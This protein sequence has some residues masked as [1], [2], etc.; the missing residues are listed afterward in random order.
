MFISVFLFVFDEIVIQSQC[1]QRLIFIGADRGVVIPFD[2]E[3]N[4]A[5]I[6]RRIFDQPVDIHVL[7][8][9]KI[10]GGSAP[11]GLID[12]VGILIVRVLCAR[13]Y[14]KLRCKSMR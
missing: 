12:T 1:I 14:G 8:V 5:R 6:F 4:R 10:F 7:L 9:Q 11:C 2:A 13:N 3:E